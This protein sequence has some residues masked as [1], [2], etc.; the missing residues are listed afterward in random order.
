MKRQIDL[1]REGAQICYYNVEG[2]LTDLYL[3]EYLMELLKRLAPAEDRR[4]YLLDLPLR[5]RVLAEL[6]RI[7]ARLKDCGLNNAGAIVISTKGS[8]P[9]EL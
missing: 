1:E 4:G 5:K 9:D 7:E 8:D 2:D 3:Y 6:D